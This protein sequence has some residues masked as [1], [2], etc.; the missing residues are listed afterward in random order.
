MDAPI[1]YTDYMSR[2]NDEDQARNFLKRVMDIGFCIDDFN[3]DSI[4]RLPAAEVI[5]ISKEVFPIYYLETIDFKGQY[6][7]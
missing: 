4:D 6:I 7:Q 2:L 1:T 5:R 3:K